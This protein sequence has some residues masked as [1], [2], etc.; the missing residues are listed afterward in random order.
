MCFAKNVFWSQLIYYL[1]LWLCTNILYIHLD[2]NG[3]KTVVYT[4]PSTHLFQNDIVFLA[5][6]HKSNLAI[7][8]Y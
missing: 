8:I 4:L 2:I 6:A 3:Y 7:W 5:S 1:I